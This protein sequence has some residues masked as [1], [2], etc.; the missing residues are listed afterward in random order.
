[1]K[2]PHEDEAGCLR[3]TSTP[4]VIGTVVLLLVVVV[5][6]AANSPVRS[7]FPYAFAVGLVAWKQGMSA[8]LLF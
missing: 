6:L 3:W 8:G 5:G 4:I 7:I 2:P 1:M